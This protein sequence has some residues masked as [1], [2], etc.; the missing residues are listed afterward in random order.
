MST[1]SFRQL[2]Y[3]FPLRVQLPIVTCADMAL[4]ISTDL[5]FT[6][7]CNS[8]LSASIKGV[9]TFVVCLNCSTNFMVVLLIHIGGCNHSG[10]L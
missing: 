2:L 8:S 3:D 7:L 6:V 4:A 1:A 10:L 5:C 9:L